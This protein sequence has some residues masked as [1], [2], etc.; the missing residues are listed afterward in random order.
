MQEQKE[1]AFKTMESDLSQLVSQ[2]S[3]LKEYVKQLE[4]N[5]EVVVKFLSNRCPELIKE[6]QQNISFSELELLKTQSAQAIQKDF[7]K[8]L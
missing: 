7:K 4:N 6:L 2:N 3:T 8:T 1:S 5:R